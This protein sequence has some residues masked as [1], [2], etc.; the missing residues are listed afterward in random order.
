MGP[1]AV[2]TTVAALLHRAGHPVLLCGHTPRAII[3]LRPDPEVL[4][5]DP[6][7]VPGP[8][9]TDPA[10]VGGPVDVLILAVKATQNAAAAGWLARL[11]DER[12]VVAVL[13]NGVEQLEQVQPLCPSSTVVPGSV[14]YSA[15]TQPDGWVRLRGEAALV[16]PTG[17]AA[18]ALADLLRGAGCRVDCD[19]DFTTVIWRKLLLNA[20]AG[21]MVLTGRRSGMFRRDDVADLSRR[22]VAE[23]V[24]VARAEGA[25]LGDDVVARIVDSFRVVPE[26]MTTSILTDREHHR[27]LEWDLRNGVIIRKARAHG[28]PTPISDV[29][30]PLLAAASEGPG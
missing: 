9:H 22:Y 10:D 24:A 11:C 2:G 29:I 13:Q 21:L 19:P 7:V 3:E 23:C 1:G 4:A 28:L 6:I 30:V 8:V 26:D 15:E 12:T 5:G 16:L 20:L 18:E 14:W 27:P 25:R 17:P